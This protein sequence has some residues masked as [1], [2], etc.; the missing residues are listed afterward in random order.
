MSQNGKKVVAYYTG[1]KKQGIGTYIVSTEESA[2][3]YLQSPTSTKVEFFDL[4]GNGKVILY[5]HIYDGVFIDLETGDGGTVYDKNT[6]G[7]VSGLVPMDFPR[8]P[9]FWGP[10]IASQEG[11]RILLAGIPEGKKNPEFFLLSYETKQ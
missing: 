2:I 10:R 9:A 4:T 5:K 11:T 8:F 6:P 7:Y 3:A 1:K